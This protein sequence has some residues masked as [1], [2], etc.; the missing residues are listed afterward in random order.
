MDGATERRIVYV[1]CLVVAVLGLLTLSR[2]LSRV[3]LKSIGVSLGLIAISI[4]TAIAASR[5]GQLD[6]TI[7]DAAANEGGLD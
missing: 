3:D 6:R 7:E 1:L 5:S 2:S 4:V